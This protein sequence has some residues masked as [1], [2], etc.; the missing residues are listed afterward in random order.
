MTADRSLAGPIVI[1]MGGDSSSLGGSSI[2][3]LLLSV[4]CQHVVHALFS[5]S[6]RFQPMGFLYHVNLPQST[7]LPY[8]AQHC[9]NYDGLR[10]DHRKECYRS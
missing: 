8:N 3:S 5:V 10:G 2:S 9:T 4:T 7:S 1:C 6:G